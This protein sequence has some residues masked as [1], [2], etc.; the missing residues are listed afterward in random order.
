MAFWKWFAIACMV[1]GLLLNMG[2]CPTLT[3]SQV[4]MFNEAAQGAVKTAQ[5]A[6]MQGFAVVDLPISFTWRT[7]TG[8][9]QPAR[10]LFIVSANPAAEK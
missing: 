8:F 7:E 3:E 10:I 6:G 1:I 4:K 9:G 2:G 5:D